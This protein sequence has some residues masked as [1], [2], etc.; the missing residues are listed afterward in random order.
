MKNPWTRQN[1]I[2]YKQN[3]DFNVLWND[4]KTVKEQLP[5]KEPSSDEKAKKSKC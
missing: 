3:I 2:K 1:I 4:L 5:K